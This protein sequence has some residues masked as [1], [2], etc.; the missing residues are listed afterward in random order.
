ME[1]QGE[2]VLAESKQKKTQAFSNPIEILVIVMNHLWRIMS[3][4]SVHI[5]KTTLSSHL[6]K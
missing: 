1:D 3:Q 4:S 5:T 6:S 2:Y